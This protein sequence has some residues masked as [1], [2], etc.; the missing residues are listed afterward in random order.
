MHQPAVSHGS[1]HKRKRKLEP[2]NCGAQIACSKGNSVPR[3]KRDIVE[4]TAI[5]AKRNLPF[6]STIQVVE[7]GFRNSLAGDRAEVLDA[8]HTGRSNGSGGSRHCCV[9][10]TLRQADILPLCESARNGE[11]LWED[12]FRAWQAILPAI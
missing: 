10:V 9:L 3:T 8:D 12:C 4:D 6:S 1:Q 2:E 5:L 7:D 11:V